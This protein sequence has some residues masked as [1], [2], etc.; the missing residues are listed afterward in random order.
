MKIAE[1]Y[2]HLN[3]Y[4]WLMY[5]KPQLFSEIKEVINSIDPSVHKT[6]KSEEKTM[7]GRMLYNPSSINS[8]MKEQF[9]DLGWNKQQY[10]YWLTDDVDLIRTTLSYKG[11]DQRRIIEEAGNEAIR[12]YNEIDLGI[13]I[14]P[15]KEMQ[16]EMSSG[17]GYYEKALY[18]LVRQG[19]G[20]PAVPLILIGIVP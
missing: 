8:F 5:K 12:S 13:E 11:K 18:D 3:G 9:N 10:Y 15:M 4:E 2:S 17:P 6:K 20:V 16:K 1:Y 7:K 19:R 14:L